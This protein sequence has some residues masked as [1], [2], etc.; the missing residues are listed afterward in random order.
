[1]I[2]KKIVLTAIPALAVLGLLASFLLGHKEEKKKSSFSKSQLEQTEQS[3]ESSDDTERLD[4]NEQIDQHAHSDE[5]NQGSNGS[6]SSNQLKIYP[7]NF[8]FKKE[9]EKLS[10][11]KKNY[12]ESKRELIEII[13]SKNKYR[14]AKAHSAA[15]LAQRQQGAIKVEALK[16][17][18]D[19]EKDKSLLRKDLV[20][21]T[22]KAEDPVISKIASAA[23]ES[24][25]NGR[26]FFSDTVNALENL[27][28]P[29]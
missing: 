27:P 2:N 23:H 12:P 14:S 21:I 6:S 24:L 15:E 25:Q 1:L 11:L 28:I 5:Y 17:V 4:A 18:F 29:E 19:L 16:A 8:D 26:P 9:T 7:K 10:E 20:S 3:Q 22:E 13:L